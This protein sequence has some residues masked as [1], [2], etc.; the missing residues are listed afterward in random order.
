MEN[1]NA[2]K[3]Q[4][5]EIVSLGEVAS[6]AGWDQ[7]V[8]M[9]HGGAEARANQLATL[10]KVI[11]QMSTSDELGEL[12][13]K[14]QADVA[15][16]DPDSDD[17]R[18]A[19]VAARDYRV[20][21][22]FPTD[23]VVEFSKTTTIGHETWAKARQDKDFEQFRP[24]LEKIVEL[25]QQRAEYLGYEEHIYD[26]LLDLFEPGMKTSHVET[27]FNGLR[28]ELVP[29][30][31]AIFDKVDSISDE[32][33]HRHFPTD[34]QR[35][36]GLKVVQQIGYDLSRGRQD[37]AVH[38]FCTSFSSNDVRI[39][40]RFDENFL[41]PALFGSIHEAGHATYE[42]GI[43][44]HLV[45]TIL[46]SGVSLG[47]HESQSRLWENLVGRSYGFWEFFYADLQK[48]YGGILDDVSLDAFYQAIN[49][50]QPSFIRVEADEVTYPLHIMMRFEI[51]KDLLTGKLAV[52]DAPAAWNA[53]TEEFLGI[54]PSDDAEGVLQDVHWSAGIFGYFPTYAL[55][56]LLSS[57]LYDK[58]LE[59]YPNIPEDVRVGK[60]DDLLSWMN[61]N[62]HAHGRKFMPA[63][64]VQRATGQELAYQPFMAY[65]RTKFGEIY[66][67]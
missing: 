14:A 15:D 32:P 46:G 17:A 21:T 36:F 10:S 23:F 62:I 67:I 45:S 50:V 43:S 59:Q 8:N 11:H 12:I 28:E 37:E 61:V 56:T 66:D 49:K 24:T 65:L 41:S 48:V 51:E 5:S 58:A 60:F 1:I 2:L 4:T 53:Y 57:Q 54:T 39:T 25:C 26:A 6:L 16:L 34:M 13:E 9:P 29:F 40:T 63:D 38:P 47:V 18:F 35:E 31:S 7:Q 52:K 30:A 64:L 20:A 27:I 33:I 42:Q 19:E 3:Q 44:K 55:G 22:C